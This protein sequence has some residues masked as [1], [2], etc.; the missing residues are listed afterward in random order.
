[1]KPGSL[2]SQN[3]T[4]GTC[5]ALPDFVS[6]GMHCRPDTVI[7]KL[8][9]ADRPAPF[10]GVA[11]FF[12][13]VTVLVAGL[14]AAPLATSL[15]ARAQLVSFESHSV[16]EGLSQSSVF[17][18]A[19][20]SSGFLWLGTQ[21]G[22]NRWDGHRFTSFHHDP[23][24]SLGLPDSWIAALEVD[25]RGRLFIGT[26]TGGLAVAI[27]GEEGFRRLPDA[28]LPNRAVT[29]MAEDDEGRMWVATYGGLVAFNPDSVLSRQ[30]S[31][32]SHTTFQAG[33]GSAFPAGRVLSV[34]AHPDGHVWA[35]TDTGGLVRIEPGT[36]NVTAVRAPPII[37]TIWVDADHSVWVGTGGQGLLHYTAD[38]ELLAQIGPPLDAPQQ[39]AR[40]SAVGRDHAGRLWAGTDG[41]GMYLVTH[42]TGGVVRG[43]SAAFARQ[44]GP[45]PSARHLRS[46]TVTAMH[47]NSD[48]E[49]RV[50]T[51]GGGVSR[52]H[53]FDWFDAPA[54]VLSVAE[55][56][57]R[58]YMGTDG[59][60]LIA[61]DIETGVRTAYRAAGGPAAPG[62]GQA[63][64]VLPHDRV[65]GLG[66]SGEP[67]A[68]GQSGADGVPS[69]WI[70]TGGGLAL[71][72]IGSPA[73][74]V[75]TAGSGLPDSRVF[76]TWPSRV[77]AGET[78]VGTWSGLARVH[79]IHG[80]M[81]TITS[82]PESIAGNRVI[83][84]RE[85]TDGALWVGTLGSGLSVRPGGGPAD[86]NPF[87]WY[88]RSTENLSSDIVAS[89]EEDSAGRV[90]VGTASGLDRFDRNHATEKGASTPVESGNT[91]YSVREGAL[92][93][94]WMSTNRG[95]AARGRAPGERLSWDIT[96]GL[97][98]NEFNQGAVAETAGGELLFGGIS[99]VTRFHPAAVL[100]GRAPRVVVTHIDVGA[101]RAGLLAAATMRRVEVGAG[102]QAIL[103]GVSATPLSNAGRTRIRYRILDGAA[104]PTA[105]GRTATERT[106]TGSAWRELAEGERSFVVTGLAGGMHTLEIQALA[107]SHGAGPIHRL[108]LQV[109]PPL[110]ARTWFRILLVL[111]GIA[112]VASIS[113]ILN[114]RKI[115]S[116]R[117]EQ[118]EQQEIHHRLMQSR[119]MERL[120]LAQ[121]LHDGAMQ[122]LYGVRYSLPEGSNGAG[123]K[124]QTVI[125]RLREIC[126]ELRP[127]VL[128]PFGLE[129]AIRAYA[130]TVA[131]RA[132]GLRMDLDLDADGQRIADHARLA[133]YRMVQE[134]AW[135]VVKH[136]GATRLG[137]RMRMESG[138]V[139]LEIEDDGKG[140]HVPASFVDLGRSNHFGL[141]G[142]RERVLSLGGTLTVESRPGKGTRIRIV[143]P[144]VAG[145]QRSD[146]EGGDVA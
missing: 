63:G 137:I 111:F 141:M 47:R 52:M 38:G 4:F 112:A 59:Q 77:H 140:F 108:S 65:L 75:W 131:E 41:A 43:R 118:R 6:W 127:S 90:W 78:W 139:H 133:L 51:N 73:A 3:M 5:R 37:L 19:E 28:L 31:G 17:A 33:D 83:E 87:S 25:S 97:Q 62:S 121:E 107:A 66:L 32:T 40:I 26:H 120:R 56:N 122:D 81:E 9:A 138:D 1:M 94:I 16:E 104:G 116:M 88:A 23:S 49:F 115:A 144:G 50:A 11:R 20:D 13:P 143:V 135:N 36:G 105:N 136:A 130:D 35:G 114:R 61:E 7:G 53:L 15:P 102:E 92:G 57:G 10:A 109:T 103:V 125:S 106:A 22:L 69:L 91:V 72:P 110:L 142:M 71:W 132:P 55:V 45:G 95:L 42:G 74:R 84:V 99:G 82:G 2:R 123:D 124:I 85:T 54:S 34:I 128:A 21:D 64:R 117:A 76:T 14:I 27:P 145:G 101:R 8:Q 30:H 86:G 67:G 134:G 48:G 113:E 24:D 12:L 44:V 68:G 89:V 18:V 129:R 80:V 100:G 126:G 60:G 98:N 146:F 93:H 46:G 58:I 79:P 39:A 29:D 70:A 119:E 96:H